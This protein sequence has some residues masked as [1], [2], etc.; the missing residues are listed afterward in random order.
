MRNI[1]LKVL[2]E[3]FMN[4]SYFVLALS[5]GFSIMDSSRFVENWKSFLLHPLN[6]FYMIIL[7]PCAITIYTLSKMHHPSNQHLKA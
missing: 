1:V 3:I 2:Y 6:Y 4:I 5:I 7:I